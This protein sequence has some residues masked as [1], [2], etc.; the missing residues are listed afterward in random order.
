MK[1]YGLSDKFYKG[2]GHKRDNVKGPL[3]KMG[4]RNWW[5]E[6]AESIDKKSARQK[7]KRQIDKDVSES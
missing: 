2:H 6:A 5:E 7:S 1:A 4:L 3:K